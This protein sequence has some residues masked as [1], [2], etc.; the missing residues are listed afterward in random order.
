MGPLTL[1]RR[2]FGRAWNDRVLG[3]AAE[4]GFWQLLSLPPLLLAVLGTIGYVGDAVGRDTTASIRDSLLHGASDLLTPSVMTDVVRPTV[5]E[6]MFR[7]RPD[8]I[9]IGFLLSLWSGSSAMATYVN[10][11]TIAYGQRELRSAVSSRLLALRLYVAQVI[12]GIVLLPSLVL[13]PDLIARLLDADRH[14][15]VSTLITTLFWPVVAILS[16]AILTSLYH[17]APPIRTQWR[18]AVPGALLAVLLWLVGSYLLRMYLEL[19]FGNELVYGSL[20]APVA[21][22]LFFYI[23]ALAVLLGAELNA[24]LYEEAKARASAEPPPS[25]AG[26]SG[27]GQGGRRRWWRRSGPRPPES[28]RAN[29][30]PHGVPGPPDPAGPA[31]PARPP[32]A[33]GSPTLPGQGRSDSPDRP[34][35][36]VRST[37]SPARPALDDGRLDPTPPAPAGRRAD[38][39]TPGGRVGG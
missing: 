26:P 1:A 8:V 21:A 20:A 6:I 17:L 16:L 23:T 31:G 24:A 5:D 39:A 30:V 37:P 19:V 36:I 4:A 14:H 12:T 35:P 18:H 10:T 22:L 28:P 9:S 15:L 38:P 32:A 33:P 25:G 29:P 27:T 2:T 7:G 11:I 34:P 13:G 3:L